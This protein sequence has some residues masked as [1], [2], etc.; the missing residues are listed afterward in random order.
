VLTTL[1]ALD[2]KYLQKS[3][4]GAPRNRDIHLLLVHLRKA[5]SL[6]YRSYGNLYHGLRSCCSACST[7]GLPCSSAGNCAVAAQT[8]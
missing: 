8:T 1:E 2:T 7:V 3:S 6:P 4:V 5:G